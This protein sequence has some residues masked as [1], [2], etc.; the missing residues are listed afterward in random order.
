ME[1]VKHV[2]KPSKSIEGVSNS[3]LV[4]H[5]GH[6]VIYVEGDKSYSFQG[7]TT[8]TLTD[9]HYH[10]VSVARESVIFFLSE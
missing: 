6:V 8:V 2:I 9:K 4:V 1:C 5:K 10:I 3:I 7:P